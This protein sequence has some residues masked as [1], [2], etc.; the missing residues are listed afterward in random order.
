[1][2]PK[3]ADE[4]ELTL[5][6]AQID[7]SL[8]ALKERMRFR[9]SYSEKNQQDISAALGAAHCIKRWGGEL[10]MY[11]QS[12]ADIR[13][14]SIRRAYS[15]VELAEST[16]QALKKELQTGGLADTKRRIRAAA[17]DDFLAH[18][19]DLHAAGY[20][21]A[22]AIVAGCALE[23]HVRRM[24]ERTLTT[25]GKFDS[26]VSALQKSG[27]IDRNEAKVLR[28]AYGF[29]SAAAHGEAL[30]KAT[31]TVANMISSVRAFLAYHEP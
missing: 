8:A 26:N 1:M 16:L 19:E 22:A 27:S 6:I 14:L 29:R 21:E 4:R 17:N 20:R 7:Q 9:S 2:A 28:S 5:A 12:A 11:V 31:G 25:P 3:D 30:P 10:H 23:I 13:D 24:T 15:A 18:A